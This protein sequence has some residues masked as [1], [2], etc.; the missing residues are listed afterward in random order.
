MQNTRL[1]IEKTLHQLDI[2][3][4]KVNGHVYVDKGASLTVV[5]REVPMYVRIDLKRKVAPCKIKLGYKEEEDLMVYYSFENANP[6]AH[7]HL[8]RVEKPTVVLVYEMD[9]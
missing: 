1:D 6:N 7:Y 3:T 5:E 2:V 4:G 9:K 8:K